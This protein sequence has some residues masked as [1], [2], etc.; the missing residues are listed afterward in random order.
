[1]RQLTADEMKMMDDPVTYEIKFGEFR[2]PVEVDQTMD[3]HSIRLV[4][5]RSWKQRLFS[6]PWR[7]WRKTTEVTFDTRG[8]PKI[9]TDGTHMRVHFQVDRDSVSFDE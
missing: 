9:E 1:M 4:Y 6:R 7:P 2:L 3:G 5:T 8:T